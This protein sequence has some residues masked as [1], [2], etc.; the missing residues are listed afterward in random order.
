MSDIVIFF[1]MTFISA[2]GL[3][4]ANY[5]VRR[6]KFKE[7]MTLIEKGIDIKDF[8]QKKAWY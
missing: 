6:A 5:F 7:K 3:F 2:I 8:L 1:C 4:L